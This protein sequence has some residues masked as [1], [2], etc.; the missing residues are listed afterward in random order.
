MKIMVTMTMMMMVVMTHTG[1]LK[2]LYRKCLTAIFTVRLRGG[3]AA[4]HIDVEDQSWCTLRTS[5]R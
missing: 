3:S 5:P 4:G 2:L 1:S